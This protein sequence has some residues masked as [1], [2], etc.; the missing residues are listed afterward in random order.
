MKVVGVNGIH[1]RGERNID[2]LLAEV[3]SRGC[4][5]FDVQLP[6]RSWISARWGGCKDGVLVAQNSSDGDVIVAHSFG[7]LRAWHAHQVREYKAIVC[8]APAM[9]E[10][11]IWR[12]PERVHCYHSRKDLAIRIG[13]R[14]LFHPFGAA[15]TDGFEQPGVHNHQAVAGHNDYFFGELLE[16]VASHLCELAKA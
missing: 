4:D 9:S 16:R 2:L 13:A 14:L 12:Y 15:G 6:M 3:A 8:I 11:A 7:C 1:T 10:S 5:V